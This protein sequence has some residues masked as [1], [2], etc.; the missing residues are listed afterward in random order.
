M[1]EKKK[2]NQIKNMEVIEADSS[3]DECVK[4]QLAFRDRLYVLAME[5]ERK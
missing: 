4:R 1:E 2:M 3:F 5:A